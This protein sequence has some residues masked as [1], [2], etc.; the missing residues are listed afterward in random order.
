MTDYFP[1][2]IPDISVKSGRIKLVIYGPKPPT[3]A[4]IQM[5]ST[6]ITNEQNI[7]NNH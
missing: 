1:G 7:I 5:P 6:S 2:L 3:D 4:V